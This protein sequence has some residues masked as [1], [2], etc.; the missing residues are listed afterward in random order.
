MKKLTYILLTLVF[1][2]CKSE[3]KDIFQEYNGEM[4]KVE[5]ID[6]K[7][8]SLFTGFGGETY[9]NGKLKSLSYV[10]NGMPADT[11]FYYYEN[12]KTKK[13]GLV[14]NG[15]QKGW[16]IYYRED[17]SLKEKSEWLTLRDSLYKN[18]SIDFDQNG[19]IKYKNSSFF[20]L[21]IPDTIQ[22]GK[23]IASFDYNSNIE[24][25]KK[26]MYVVIKNK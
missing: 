20:N 10:K 25:Y 21:K 23:N 22:T 1:I 12:G 16:W 4:V 26:L 18:Q 14:E 6:S 9:E 5:F 8:D 24:V 11:L 3:K 19:E 13:K 2:N 7:A 15:F 17:G